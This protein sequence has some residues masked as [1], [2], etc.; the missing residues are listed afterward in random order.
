MRS[1]MAN[2]RAPDTRARTRGYLR[3][4]ARTKSI[5]SPV[6]PA[7]SRALQKEV[8][9]VGPEEVADDVALLQQ[10]RHG[11]Q[12]LPRLRRESGRNLPRG[13]V[14]HELQLDAENFVV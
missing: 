2:S 8:G 6:Y 10:R 11:L 13:D 14:L 7:L 3:L 12:S 4:S 9:H 1:V 5:V